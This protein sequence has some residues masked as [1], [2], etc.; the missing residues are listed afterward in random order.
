MITITWY[1]ELRPETAT[2]VRHSLGMAVELTHCEG[3]VGDQLVASREL[4]HTLGHIGS[5]H[6]LHLI[7]L[8]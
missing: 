8:N 1:V 4:V 3:I 5:W 6:P 2:V 7:H